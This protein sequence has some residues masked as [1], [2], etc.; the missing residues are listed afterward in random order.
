M[1]ADENTHPT[2]RK[3]KLAEW[4]C[5]YAIIAVVSFIVISISECMAMRMWP[6]GFR[7]SLKQSMLLS[8]TVACVALPFMAI[9]T[10]RSFGWIFAAIPGAFFAGLLP[11]PGSA[12]LILI[13]CCLLIRLIAPTAWP[14]FPPWCCRNCSYDLRGLPADATACPECGTPTP[15]GRTA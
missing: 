15:A 4:W 6:V 8:A 14:S 10:T 2:T 3:P 5:R 12:L 1:P 13:P 9:L 11:P 7:L